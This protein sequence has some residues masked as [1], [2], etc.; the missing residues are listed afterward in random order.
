ME[1]TPLHGTSSKSGR[2]GAKSGFGASESCTRKAVSARFIWSGGS[3]PR[4]SFRIEASEPTCGGLRRCRNAGSPAPNRRRR[5]RGGSSPEF[6]RGSRITR[7]GFEGSSGRSIGG[8]ASRRGRR[9][10]SRRRCRRRGR[11]SLVSSSAERPFPPRTSTKFLRI[12]APRWKNQRT[13]RRLSRTP[14]K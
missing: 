13:T 7:R 11:A 2:P 14:P 6:A 10:L 12:K 8:G 1:W 4:G 9:S 3:S 5:R